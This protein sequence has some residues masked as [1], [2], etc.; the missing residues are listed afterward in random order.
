MSNFEDGT[1]YDLKPMNSDVQSF[2]GK[3][4]VFVDGNRK[5]LLSY[6]LKVCEVDTET[7]KWNILCTENDLSLTTCRHIKEFLWQETG[8]EYSKKDYVAALK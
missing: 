3:A 1:L 7:K 2:Y 4:E 6:K 8:Q 5:I